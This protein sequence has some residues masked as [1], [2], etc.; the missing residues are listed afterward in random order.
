MKHKCTG[1][2]Q[3]K[4]QHGWDINLYR[5]KEKGYIGGVC[6]GLADHF[7]VDAW[8]VRLFTFGGF[9]FLG[10]FVVMGY[11]A[12]WWFLSPRPDVDGYDYDYEYDERQHS[13]RPKKM[14]KYSASANVRLRRAKERLDEVKGRVTEMETHVTSRKFDLEREFSKMRD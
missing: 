4:K 8:V 5:N 2:M 12:L 1:N 10:G 6:A 3:Q 14:F 9:L 7:D 11:I 13:Y